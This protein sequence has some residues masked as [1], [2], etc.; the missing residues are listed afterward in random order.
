MI[1]RP[2]I[3]KRLL[4]GL[5]VLGLGLLT[6]ACMLAPG[7]FVSELD[8]RQDGG[9]TFTY[10]GEIHVLALSGKERKYKAFTPSPC[11]DDEGQDRACSKAELAEQRRAWEA[12]A[13][14]RKKRDQQQAQI[15]Q[16]LMGGVDPSDPQSAE[17]LAERLRKQA[18]YRK[19]EYKGNGV[20]M[21]DYT[22]DSRLTHD[23]S[24]PAIERFPMANAFLQL[25]ARQ[26]RIVRLDAS[27]FS[28]TSGNPAAGMMGAPGMDGPTPPELDGRFTLTA[29]GAILSNNTE[30]GPEQINGRQ[31]MSWTINKHTQA[32]PMAVIQLGN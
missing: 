26:D 5:G 15:G 32:A 2:A 19:V 18:G 3:A 20:Y 7:K 11:Q 14:E 10:Q 17:A 24:F 29:D 23:F 21:V 22:I 8:L 28:P 4:A 13:R 25:T 9:F 30:D 27:G 16:V 1:N 6:A 31:R 12:D